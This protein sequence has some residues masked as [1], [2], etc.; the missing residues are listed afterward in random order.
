MIDNNHYPP[1][2]E[3]AISQP[4]RNVGRVE[5]QVVALAEKRKL[6]EAWIWAKQEL[7]VAQSHFA[8]ANATWKRADKRKEALL[9]GDPISGWF[10]SFCAVSLFSCEAALSSVLPKLY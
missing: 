8:K 9:D 4:I 6:R 1:L 10:Y 7:K 2:N 5:G 3:E